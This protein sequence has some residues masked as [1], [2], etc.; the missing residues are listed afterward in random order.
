M[1]NNRIEYL[2]KISETFIKAVE[3]GTAV[4][5]KP[6]KASTALMPH[7]PVTGSVYQGFNN[8]YLSILQM[9]YNS[10]DSRWMTFLNAKDNGY[11]IKQGSKA[12]CITYFTQT[13]VDQNG[14]VIS[15]D[16]DQPTTR[17]IPTL[18]H[19][20]VFHASQ[21][22]GLPDIHIEPVPDLKENHNKAQIF[23]ENTG[24]EIYNSQSDRCFYNRSKDQIH[25]VPPSNFVS[26]G[27]YYSTLIHELSHW[28]GHEARLNR[29]SGGRFGSDE[30]A[31][32]E[33]RA[34]IAAYMLSRELKIDF[35]PRN[36]EAY[37]TSWCRDF[38]NKPEEI[39]KACHDALSIKNYCNELQMTRSI[40][41]PQHHREHTAD[42]S[43]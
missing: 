9:Q 40:D 3:D 37:V 21:I 43:L 30:Y 25:M 10:E 42:I 11:K 17:F 39:I 19:F 24:A 29:G 15:K 5:M 38:E 13:P 8:I 22:E 18:K 16:S 26:S 27:E 1:N 35:N 7:N 23:I 31:R 6:W 20:H 36:N 2:D 4:F 41:S 14:K 12:A 34:E 33:L 32:E 28:T